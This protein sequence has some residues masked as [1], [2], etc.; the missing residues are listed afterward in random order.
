MF[1]GCMSMDA[2]SLELCNHGYNYYYT[3]INIIRWL[4]LHSVYGINS[5]NV[6]MTTRVNCGSSFVLTSKYYYQHYATTVSWM[7]NYLL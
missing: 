3:T 4:I 5:P 2:Q 6:S 1:A 7:R